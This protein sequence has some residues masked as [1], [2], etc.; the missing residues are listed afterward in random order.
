[1]RDGVLLFSF[2]VILFNYGKKQEKT[3][4]CGDVFRGGFIGGSCFA[5]TTR[6]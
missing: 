6:L 3:G 2:S 1:M 5:A 4:N